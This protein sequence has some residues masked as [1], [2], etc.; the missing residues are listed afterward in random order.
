ME[1]LEDKELWTRVRQGDTAAFSL[2][3]DQYWEDMFSIAWRRIGDEGHAKDLVQNIFIRCWEHR[4]D[5]EVTN[6]LA[7]YL[8]TALKYSVVRHIYKAARKGVTD[9]PLSV[10]Q[11]P[12][13]E[14]PF[15]SDWENFQQVQEAINAEVVAMPRRMQQVFR[16]HQE[17]QLSI[18][19]IALQLSISEQTVK[20]TFHTAITR[21]R[22]RLKSFDT[23][24]LFL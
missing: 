19:A 9:L 5:I 12:E 3:F 11:I 7:P 15:L 14:Q 4:Q 24:L 22:T 10:Y 16:L 8:M 23:F 1:F 21:L 13:E 17:Q 20:N 18:K 6:S 2:L